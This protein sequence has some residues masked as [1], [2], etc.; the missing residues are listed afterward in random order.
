MDK[1]GLRVVKNHQGGMISTNNLRYSQ[2]PNNEEN[3]NTNIPYII[4]KPI[5]RFNL[6]RNHHDDRYNGY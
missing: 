1:L 4:Q 5:H 2:E 3:N 6:T